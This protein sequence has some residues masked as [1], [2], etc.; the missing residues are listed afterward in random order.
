[1][2]D[3][4]PRGADASGRAA[5]RGPAQ[6]GLLQPAPEAATGGHGV[7]GE[8]LGQDQADQVGPPVGVLLTQG[9][10]L[11]DE[12]RIALR[13]GGGPVIGGRSLSAGV[14]PL[15]QQVVDGA[16]RQLKP[17]RQG[18]GG[19]PA[20]VA[21]EHGLTDWHGNGARHGNSLLNKTPGRACAQSL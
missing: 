3:G 15:A 4:R 16:D 18:Q 1:M 13:P 6:A 11:A 9:L 7:L 5:G 10:G 8:M 19:Q 14:P 2:H 12:P 21:A 20:L 17:L